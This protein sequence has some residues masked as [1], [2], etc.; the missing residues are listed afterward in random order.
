MSITI[1]EVV[2][3]DIRFPTSDGLH[4]SDAIHKA[5][6]YSC[7]YVT[8][9]TD[10]PGLEGHGICFTLGR[11]N[12]ICAAAVEALRF[13]VE[14]R[15]LEAIFA[16]MRGFWYELSNDG[17][18]RW[19]GPDK[20]AVHFAVAAVVNAI[21]DLQAR[22]A[23]KPLWQLLADMAPEALVDCIE[24]RNISDALTPED[25]VA[26]LREH[27][28][29]R[30]SRATE[31]AET[32][33]PSYTSSAGWLGYSDSQVRDLVQKYMAAGW[34]RFKMKVGVDI[35]AE[36]SRARLIR[37]EIGAHGILMT[38]ANQVWSVEQAIASMQA[39][40]PFEPLWIEEPVHPDD[41]FGHAKVAEAVA[42]IGVAV[43][44]CISNSVLYK[45]FMQAGAMSFCQIDS[46]RLGGV[47]EV[48]A[49]ILM[50]A[51]FGIPVCPHAGGVGLCEYVQ[52]LAAFNCVAVA[53]SLENVVIEYSDHLHEHF[54]D[55]VVIRDGRYQLPTQP[56]YSIAMKPESL[57]AYD[58]PQGAVWRSR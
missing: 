44:E 18:L 24:F 2:V 6:D 19:L 43:G 37:E 17:Q 9:K 38:D 58:F 35:D 39:L 46:C 3:R 34:T 41:I 10:V 42:P 28:A 23:G 31:L 5:P 30:R 16:D 13:L 20:G 11:G 26:I 29:T 54:I 25:A 56:G 22:T 53:P 51:K 7:P 48:L 14:G 21:W 32:G 1:T 27:A 4:G 47:N 15:V 8:L 55:P 57:A 50:A 36:V 12:E 49:V 45:Q 40:A 33:M 52:H